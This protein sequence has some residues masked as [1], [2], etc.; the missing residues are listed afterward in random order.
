MK[1]LVLAAVFLVGASAALAADISKITCSFRYEG[2]K[3]GKSNVVSCSMSPQNVFSTDKTQQPGSEMCDQKS[4]RHQEN[5][6]DYTVDI[7]AKTI[8]YVGVLQMSDYL[9]P[10][11]IADGIKKG[12]TR[13]AATADANQI[14]KRN[15]TH[16]IDSIDVGVREVYT[17]PSGGYYN[18]AKQIP[19]YA[20]RYGESILYYTVGVPEAVIVEPTGDERH[21]WVGMRFGLCES[22]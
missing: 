12:E 6:L 4:N 8:T 18:P 22:E 9:K 17:K 15:W 5:F 11:W 16:K 7:E 19:T 10:E 3:G 1:R 14:T 21:T 2:H 13:D 20:V